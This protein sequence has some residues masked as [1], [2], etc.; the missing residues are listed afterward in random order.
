[1]RHKNSGLFRL[2]VL[3]LCAG[4]LMTSTLPTPAKAQSTA[5]QVRVIQPINDQLL[6][7]LRGNTPA[8]I[9]KA[10]NLGAAGDDLP[11]ARMQLVL[12]PSD[13]QQADLV[14]LLTNQQKPN[15]PDYHKWL[16]PTQFGERFGAAQADVDKITAWLTLHGFTIDSVSNS[17]TVIT[18]SG[19]AKQLSSAFHT[20]IHQ[21]SIGGQKHY[22]NASDPMIPTAIT[23]VVAGFSSLTTYGRTPQHTA[24]RIAMRSN[25]GK[26]SVKPGA[27]P[28]LAS[29]GKAGLGARPQLTYPDGN[30]G[31]YY[32][33]TPGDFNTIYNVS[34]LISQG[35]DGTGVSIAIVAE[36]D[37]NPDDVNGFRTTF[38]LPAAK[39]NNIVVGTDP[40]YTGDSNESEADLDT[41]WS[42]A[43]A[44]NAT[45][46]LLASAPTN[47]GGG[48]LSAAEYAVDNN[49]SPILS[50]SWGAC[51]FALGTSG[52][53]YFYGLWQQA[54]V[55]GITVVVSSGDAG[56]ASCDQNEEAS[57]YGEQVSGFASTPYNTAVGG[58]DFS[59]NDFGTGTVFGNFGS[60]YWSTTNN[61]N[62]GASA[63]GYVPETPWNET[64]A[65]PF[66]LT[67]AQAQTGTPWVSDTTTEA[68]CNDF[69]VPPSSLT[70]EPPFLDTAGGGGGASRCTVSDGADP[71]TCSGGYP[72]P[73]WQIAM[74]GM[75]TTGF[76]SVPDISFFSGSGI[77]GSS[78]V[79]CQSDAITDDSCDGE[80]LTAGGTSFAAP[81]FAGVVALMNQ[82]LGSPL[83]NI[84]YLLYQIGAAQYNGSGP[85]VL[86]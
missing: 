69:Y 55:E 38:G 42:G 50:V 56:S 16:T 80:F 39:F 79:Y 60:Q 7:R 32:F 27:L 82:K 47:T 8:F 36:S 41:E 62:T 43:I 18:F 52:N 53:Q 76:R 71:S 15:S 86:P 61:P 28:Q 40:G 20:E 85:A 65:S 2:P 84:N 48:I 19:T 68:L 46:N 70:G 34:P 13:A 3:A 21:Y 11:L 64:C 67:A 31:N 29:T 58:T 83:G 14:K 51:E 75:P 23:P 4:L 17:R 33:V 59:G 12:K 49:L 25:D 6:V 63:L 37:V 5:P 54:S 35:T 26:W 24:P 73:D 72:T 81:A 22:A 74:P 44:P 9:H 45:I 78:L 77:W 10:T 66:V 1:M 57:Y 30:G